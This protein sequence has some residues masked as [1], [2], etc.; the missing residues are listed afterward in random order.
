M[1]SLKLG[2]MAC[3]TPTNSQVTV[4][5]L[6]QLLFS[7]QIRIVLLTVLHS[8]VWLGSAGILLHF[9]LSLC[10]PLEQSSL[11]YIF[12]K[13]TQIP[14]IWGIVAWSAP[15]GYRNITPASLLNAHASYSGR[16]LVRLK[17]RYLNVYHSCVCTASCVYCIL[18]VYCILWLFP[19]ADTRSNHAFF[20]KCQTSVQNTVG[21]ARANKI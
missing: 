10:N 21:G 17:A 2:M 16:R 11:Q 18:G 5:K 12:W 7:H 3:P 9:G 4:W 13:R 6:R 8:E 14:F 19:H 20:W 1:P 15:S